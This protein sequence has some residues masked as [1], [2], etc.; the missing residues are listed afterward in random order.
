MSLALRSRILRRGLAHTYR[1]R[2]QLETLEVRQTPATISGQVFNDL[3][4]NGLVNS[5][6][7]GFPGVSVFLDTN[8]N[9]VIDPGP[10]TTYSSANVPQ[11]ISASGTPTVTST[12][13]VP[14]VGVAFDVNVKLNISHTFDSDL[15]VSLKNPAGTSVTLFSK[16]GGNGDNF[17][18]TVLDDQAATKI[19]S[20]SAPFTGTFKPSP[21]SLSSFNGAATNGTWTLTIQDTANQDGG[22][23]NSWSIDITAAGEPA[24]TTD[25]NGNYSF[26][27]LAAGSYN[28]VHVIPSGGYVQTSPGGDG[29]YHVNLLSAGTFTGNFG[30]RLPPAT[31]AGLVFND[32]NSNGTQDSG[33]SPLSGITV[34][35]DLDNSGTLN[36][37]DTSVTTNSSGIYTFNNVVPNKDYIVA[38]VLPGGFT[39]IAPVRS[40]LQASTNVNSSKMTGEQSE[41]SVAIDP[42][43]P[44]R[45]F[46]SSNQLNGSGGM[47]GS[48]STDGGTTWSPRTFANGSDGLI[49]STGDP[50]EVFDDF[51]NLWEANLSSSGTAT[52]VT[53]STDGGKTFT[54]FQTVTAA[55]SDQPT[56]VAGPSGTPGIDLIAIVFNQA[57]GQW[58]SYLQVNSSGPT[59]GFTAPV[60]LPSSNTGI[61]GEYSDVAIGPNGQVAVAY[62]NSGGEGP[63]TIYFNLDPDGV[64]AQAFGARSILTTTNVGGFDHITPQPSRSVDAE[65]GLAY[66]RSGGPHQGRLYALYTEEVTNESNNTDIMLRHSDNNGTTWSS[67]VRVNDDNTTN[68]Q[69]LPRISL[70]QTTGYIAISWFDARNDPANA[71]SEYWATASFD[72]GATFLPNIKL[73]SGQSLP[74][75]SNDYGD[76][77]GLSFTNGRFIA[78]WPDNSNSTGD[79]P[80]GT[81]THDIYI[82]KVIV[83]N[84]TPN[85][86][87]ST[88]P[89]TTYSGRD[90]AIKG[91]NPPLT[92]TVNQD[93]LQADPTNSGT[94][95]FTVVFNQSVSDFA[96]GDVTLSGTAGATTAIVTGS[97]TTY[98]IAVSGM[99]GTGTVVASLAAGVA[100][101][102]GGANQASS[103]TDNTVN[104]DQTPP[105]ATSSPANVTISGG[106]S[107]Q[108]T[109]T[110]SDDS[111]INVGSLDNTDVR[112]TGPGGF[113]V[114]ATFVGVDNNTNGTPRVATYTFSPPGG[115][116]DTADNGTY[117]VV[118]QA[119]QV[120]DVATNTV[121]TATVG[122]FQVNVP[123]PTVTG[124]I[125]GD[126]TNQRSQVRQIVVTFS[127]PMNFMG[128]AA[129]AFTVHRSGTGGT[130]GDVALVATPNAGPTSSVTITFSGTLTES[131]NSLIDGLYNLI[132]DAA[133]VSSTTGTALDGNNDGIAG[134][135]YVVTGTTANK[136]FRLY[137]DQNGDVVVDQTDYLVFRNA[138][139]GGPNTIFDFDNSG[140][141]DQLD[142][143]AFRNR[144]SAGP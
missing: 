46:V 34:Y 97:G 68:G 37:G 49:N 83:T 137:G 63:D 85:Y 27:G 98:N 132:I 51:G 19:T 112:V 91:A 12:I 76:Y 72:G 8:N 36:A 59:G 114:P 20:G 105:T 28:V 70:D 30:D 67:P 65:I 55:S 103:S 41:A 138:I 74:G 93:A 7:A 78:T 82:A 107:Q 52:N 135:D 15:V 22:A 133:Q 4:G 21:G 109:V 71:K 44:N 95:N 66:D 1:Q 48:Y 6:E 79:N 69:F 124:I 18:N 101:G 94:I 117:S 58:A 61:S 42:T 134:G 84:N 38:E 128:G 100:N 53:R 122:S 75:G 11:T 10:T 80:S 129:A 116:W 86:L 24:T 115:T 39:H 90:F 5:G 32:T 102:A 110:Y 35:L 56:I 64:G 113:D 33:E 62:Q 3:N 50:T 121:S 140:D 81:A 144:I 126:G 104:F 89:G 111:A 77:T 31:I 17:T 54:S 13:T 130:T 87:V 118:V 96:T 26:T 136:F 43:N 120:A 16:V 92:V 99:T 88:L 142:Y 73:S 106:S 57:S 60:E 9:G 40:G 125:F 108:F 141:V 29:R 2:L 47:M 14:D 131:A 45:V 123:P 139:G 25:A 127:E 119:N 23:L 143:L